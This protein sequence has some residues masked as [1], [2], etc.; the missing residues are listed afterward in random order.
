MGQLMTP[1]AKV[2]RSDWAL[3]KG[4]RSNSGPRVRLDV[5]ACVGFRGGSGAR[6]RRDRRGTMRRPRRL[7]SRSARGPGSRHRPGAGGLGYR[8]QEGNVEGRLRSTW[9]TQPRCVHGP[10]HARVSRR[11]RRGAAPAATAAV[12]ALTQRREPAWVDRGRILLCTLQDPDSLNEVP[13]WVTGLDHAEVHAI[14]T[15]ELATWP[16]AEAVRDQVLGRAVRE[17]AG[18]IEGRWEIDPAVVAAANV[19]GTPELHDALLTRSRDGPGAPGPGIRSLARCRLRRRWANVG[20]PRARL[21]DPPRGRGRRM[22]AE[23]TSDA[24]CW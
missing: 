13:A 4:S 15:A 3:W 10:G 7:P 22:E 5:R 16:R 17:R 12:R 2:A 6:R 11:G 9:R 1:K 19:M 20:R 21:R 23:P 8:G 18:S 14:C 24:A